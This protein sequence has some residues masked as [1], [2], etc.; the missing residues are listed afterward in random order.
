MVL[1][2]RQGTFFVPPPSKNT[3]RRVKL[4]KKLSVIITAVTVVLL[5]LSSCKG[6]TD[7]YKVISITYEKAP[8]IDIRPCHEVIYEDESRYY[9]LANLES[10]YYIVRYEN[11]EKQNIKDALTE[12][13]ISVND[14]DIYKIPYFIEIK[15]Y[16]QEAEKAVQSITD[17]SQGL[18][19]SDVEEVFY[20][21]YDRIYI[22]GNPISEYITVEYTDGSTEGVKDA[23]INGNIKITDLDLHGIGYFSE[24]KLID[25]IIDL[26]ESGEISTAD[27]LEPFYRD[28]KYYYS[29]PSIKSQYITVHYKD[30]SE[31]T[32]KDALA[33][34]K[35]KI[36]DLDIFGIAYYKEPLE[37]YIE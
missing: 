23:L 14:L 6:E 30:G 7:N 22:F 12:G 2:V 34:G 8:D 29:F 36:T 1:F 19:L 31:Q 3:V 27:A 4:M 35:V 26:T 18:E 24:P 32:V 21:T 15:Q 17:N 25:S 37:N 33:E 5:C 13:R 20:E 11:G 10:E 16:R 28:N 9:L